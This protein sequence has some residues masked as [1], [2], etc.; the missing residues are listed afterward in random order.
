MLTAGFLASDSAAGLVIPGSIIS[1]VGLIMFWQN[2]T[3]HF[4]TWSYAWGLILAAVG[5]GIALQG[6]LTDSEKLSKDGR[7][8]ATLGFIFF[9]TF[10]AFFELFIF[11]NLFNSFVGRYLAAI[12]INC[13][14][15]LTALA[16][17]KWW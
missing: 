4:E 13:C 6:Y 1:T 12:C 8:L 16:L 15:S 2:L 17:P 10:G 11:R 5:L 7:Q 14:W 3:G 9:V